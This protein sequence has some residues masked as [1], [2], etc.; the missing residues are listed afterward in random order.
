MKVSGFTFLRNAVIN[1]YPFEESIRSLLPIVDEFICVIGEGK[2]GTREQVLAIADPKI[3]VIDSQWNENMKDRGF[4][5]GQQKMVAQFNCTGDWAFYLEG[6]EV[7]HESEV[8]NI[9]KTMQE[10]LEDPEVEA[11]Y[12]DFF[13]FYGTPNQVG[14]AGYRRAPRII[15]NSI[16]SIAPDGLFWTVM[17]KN[18]KGRY[19]KAKHAGGNIY[20]Y[21]HCRS[22]SKMAEK[23]KQV[24]RYWG[25]KHEEFRGY[26]SIDVRELRPFE[27][28]HPSSMENWLA[29]EAETEFFQDSDYRVTLRDRRNRL[30]FWIEDTFGVE[31]SKKHYQSLN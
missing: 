22:V 20:H 13:H 10:N 2:D 25:S 8:P 6:D 28:S 21:G 4:V 19:P 15:R 27:G 9:Y 26:G 3:R 11:L 31:I 7:L 24:G 12:F 30:R 18:K 29:T 17:D 23:L 14:I 5:Y 16:R 1:G